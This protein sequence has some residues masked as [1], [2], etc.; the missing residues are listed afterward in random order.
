[1]NLKEFAALKIGDKISN[2]VTDSEGT[3]VE[4]V[5]DRWRAGYL[6]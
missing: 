6:G 5:R 3:V 1:M 2:P 4:V